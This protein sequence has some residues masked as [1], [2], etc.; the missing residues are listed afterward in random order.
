MHFDLRTFSEEQVRCWH[1]AFATAIQAIVEQPI[2][3]TVSRLRQRV[4]E[5]I[6]LAR[7][8]KRQQLMGQLP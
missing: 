8:D 5:S 1:T 6:R 3:A 7:H 4:R 2:D